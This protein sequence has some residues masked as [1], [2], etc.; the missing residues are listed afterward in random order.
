[1]QS[2]EV[3]LKTVISVKLAVITAIM[4]VPTRNMVSTVLVMKVSKSLAPNQK[5]GNVK[6][7]MNAMLE[8]P[9]VAKTNFAQT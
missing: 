5:V 1:M 2:V 9:F 7:S 3:F 6:M 8:R 4:F